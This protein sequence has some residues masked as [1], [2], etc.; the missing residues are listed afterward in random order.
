[1]NEITLAPEAELNAVKEIISRT[2]SRNRLAQKGG[3]GRSLYEVVVGELSNSSRNTEKQ[4]E[5]LSVFEQAAALFRSAALELRKAMDILTLEQRLGAQREAISRAKK[6]TP[7][8]MY[9]ADEESA[10]ELQKELT[11]KIFFSNRYA[12]YFAGNLGLALL[13]SQKADIKNQFSFGTVADSSAN[14]DEHTEALA[15]VASQDLE[16]VIG[17][18]RGQQLEVSDEDLRYT[19]EGIFTSWVN[20]F[21]WLTF[22][23]LAGKCGLDETKLRC[24]NYSMQA[25]E[26]K[27]KSDQVVVDDRFMKV[28]RS[29]VIGS[30]EF[31]K[32]LWNNLIKLG[33]YSHDMR[34]NPY[35]PASVIFTYGEPGGGKTF[36]AHALINSFAEL[37]RQKGIPVW[38]LTHSTTDY[39]SHYQNKTANELAALAAKIN[40]FPGIVLMYVADADNIF[41]SRK[42]ERLTAEQQQTLGVYFKMFDG[43]LVPKNGKFLAIMDANYI[44]GIDD[45]TKSR[46][47]DEIVELKRFEKPE[48][49]AELAKRSLTKGTQ[50]LQ[51]TDVEWLEI[52]KYLLTC[53]LSNREIGHV[54][55]NLR[56][57]YDVPEEMLGKPFEEHEA[58][59]NQHLQGLTKQKITEKFDN[60]IRTRMEIERK[61][62]ES[63]RKEDALRFLQY[64]EQNRQ[65]AAP[66]AS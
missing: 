23:D 60:Y 8:G 39:A 14:R 50:G 13:K 3:A 42:D 51:I 24:G 64:L 33:A 40:E 32:I 61:A 58:F 27:A 18:K 20:Q 63:K 34:R 46:L 30:V 55:K 57:G 5:Y 15:R 38:A 62:Y 35:D 65:E 26:F 1:M 9:K 45:A 11:D 16:R 22:K 52:G 56:R 19:L 44:E 6:E 28:S 12:L 49:F 48:D 66:Q 21:N 41:L 59:R 25:G 4:I 54:I 53:P 10:D 36:V 29:D 31:A 7:G 43:S 47:F 2:A 37:C 17:E